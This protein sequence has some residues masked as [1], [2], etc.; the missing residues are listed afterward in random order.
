MT[1]ILM[2]YTSKT[3]NQLSNWLL[4]TIGPFP[5]QAREF[6]NNLF[7]WLHGPV[8]METAH[9]VLRTQFTKHLTEL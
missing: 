8:Q 2:S 1:P 3:E 5:D 4:F 6:K 9:L 7:V